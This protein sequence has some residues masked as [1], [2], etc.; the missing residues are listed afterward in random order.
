MRKS[1]IYILEP[2][3]VEKSGEISLLPLVWGEQPGEGGGYP[4]GGVLWAGLLH[5]YVCLSCGFE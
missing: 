3:F 1:C 4:P 2:G 5:V